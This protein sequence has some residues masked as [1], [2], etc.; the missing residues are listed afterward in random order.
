MPEQAVPRW[1][2]EGE[3]WSITRTTDELSVVAPMTSIPASVPMTGPWRAFQVE[4]PLEHDLVGVLAGLAAPLAA[5]GI[6]IFALST[7]DTDYLLVSD[8]RLEDATSALRLAG[9][10]VS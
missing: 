5:G 1:A 8:E 7:F 4:G 2:V 3:W 6:S 10:L 9:H